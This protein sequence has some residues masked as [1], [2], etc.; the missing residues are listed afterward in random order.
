MNAPP[1]LL[2]ATK[3]D[4]HP[5]E[6]ADLHG[7]RLV[8]AVETADGGY[9]S[10]ALVKQLTGGDSIRARRMREDFW[11]F[12][13]SHTVI[14]ATNHKPTIRGTDHGIWR[15]IRLVPFA[16]TI[17]DAEQD[18][19]LVAKLRAEWPAILRWAVVGC[20]DWQRNGLGA[21]AEVQQATESYRT[22]SDVLGAFLEE[23]CIVGDG[24]H[25]RAGDLY[26][27]YKRWADE[28]GEHVESLTRFG[29]RITERGFSK[30][31]DYHNR[32]V[33]LGLGLVSDTSDT[34]DTFP[35]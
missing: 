30:G 16:V 14:L 6:L 21:P 23:R 33:Y 8:A 15:R 29:G 18:K 34:S 35:V 22:E 4:R 10:E 25:V 28:H 5:T 32:V 7:K 13:V 11:Q 1:G 26:Q 27:A 12:Q 2:M 31:R 3:S 24:R 17:P 19:Q 20:I 9:L